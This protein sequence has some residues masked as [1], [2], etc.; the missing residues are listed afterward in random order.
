MIIRIMKVFREIA[1]IPQISVAFLCNIMED[2]NI[3][4]CP[5]IYANA[6]MRSFKQN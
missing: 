2:S 6:F 1:F 3:M 4:N 5:L